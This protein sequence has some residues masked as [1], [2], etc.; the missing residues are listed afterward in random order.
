MAF[1]R[2]PFRGWFNPLPCRR[3]VQLS[4]PSRWPPSESQTAVSSRGGRAAVERHLAGRF[5]CLEQCGGICRLPGWVAAAKACCAP[6]GVVSGRM[7]RR[8]SRRRLKSPVRFSECGRRCESSLGGL[9]GRLAAAAP[10]WSPKSRGY[11]SLASL[12]LAA[13]RAL[14]RGQATPRSASV[15][16]ATMPRPARYLGRVG[17]SAG[18]SFGRRCVGGLPAGPPDLPPEA[19]GRGGELARSE[20]YVIPRGRG[21]TVALDVGAAF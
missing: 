10:G 7:T 4:A 11:R 15:C 1:L 9:C 13:E 2:P 17:R 20:S 14:R 5:C 19:E 16:A 3:L 18:A 6:V 21:W 12:V 8:S